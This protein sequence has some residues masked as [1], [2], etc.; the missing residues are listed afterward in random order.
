MW[1]VIDGQRCEAFRLRSG[2]IHWTDAQRILRARAPRLDLRM[3][4]R[5][6]G[7][8]YFH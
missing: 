8:A 2:G 7:A 3:P 1:V 6:D 5:N 4:E